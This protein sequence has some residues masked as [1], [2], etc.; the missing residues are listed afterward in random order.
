VGR[1]GLLFRQ[2]LLSPAAQ[3]DVSAAA[4]AVLEL[5]SFT[6]QLIVFFPQNRTTLTQRVAS[7]W[8]KLRFSL[9]TTR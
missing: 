7:F 5:F 2:L 8:T 6:A 3:F 9:F 4:I 1:V